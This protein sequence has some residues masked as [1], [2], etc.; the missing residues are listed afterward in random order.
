MPARVLYRNARDSRQLLQHRRDLLLSFWGLEG[1]SGE[2]GTKATLEESSHKGKNI[3][4]KVS[5]CVHHP[6][7]ADRSD[8]TAATASITVVTAA[9]AAAATSTDDAA[10]TAGLRRILEDL[11]VSMGCCRTSWRLASSAQLILG[12]GVN[13]KN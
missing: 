8:Q 1:F 9:A 5:D 6:C 13:R 2:P 10:V 12:H 3:V 11:I 4:P 7:R